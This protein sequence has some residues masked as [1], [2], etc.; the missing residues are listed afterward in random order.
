MPCTRSTACGVLQNYKWIVA[1][2][3]VTADIRRCLAMGFEY[4]IE[5]YDEHRPRFACSWNGRG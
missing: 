1:P 3:P 4:K 5:T 2:C